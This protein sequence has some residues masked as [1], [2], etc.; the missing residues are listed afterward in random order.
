MRKTLGHHTTEATDKNGGMRLKILMVIS[1]AI[2]SQIAMLMTIGTRATR[3][4]PAISPAAS[5]SVSSRGVVL[6]SCARMVAAV[7]K[8]SGMPEI[9]RFMAG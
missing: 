9:N 8:N 3:P 4:H 6:A 2:Q 7:K 5:L 1:I